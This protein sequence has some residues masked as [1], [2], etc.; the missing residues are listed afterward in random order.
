V[1][2][3]KGLDPKIAKIVCVSMINDTLNQGNYNNLHLL[4]TRARQWVVAQFDELCELLTA[5]LETQSYDDLFAVEGVTY[6]A[7]GAADVHRS[8]PAL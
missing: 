6:T 1:L 3:K 5:E 8:R 2:N 4:A 7:P